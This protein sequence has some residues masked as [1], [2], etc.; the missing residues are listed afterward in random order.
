MKK[1]LAAMTA[2]LMMVALVSSTAFAAAPAGNSA[3]AK[4]CQKGGYL[5]LVGTAGPFATQD[6]C[7]NYAKTGILYPKTASL[8]SVVTGPF[9]GLGALVGNPQSRVAGGIADPAML[10]TLGG[11]SWVPGVAISLTYTAGAPLS[12]S[13][14]NPTA[15][16]PTA[17]AATAS[18]T[19]TLST[20]FQDNCFDSNNVLVSGPAIPY[21]ITGTNVDGQSASFAGTLNCDLIPATVTT[22][23]NTLAS[24]A[25][26]VLLTASGWHF[27]PNA[28]ITLSYDVTAPVLDGNYGS[29]A[30]FFT[31]PT[32]DAN[33]SFVWDSASTQLIGYYGDNC[34]YDTGSG[35]TLQTTNL[36]FTMTA[37]DG[38]HS[39]TATG[40]LKCSLLA[41]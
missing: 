32:A 15:Y 23:S 35:P 26:F 20:W 22:T 36:T 40:V 38:T 16:F 25:G 24:T 10:F 9:T 5:T 2:A 18:G 12:Y 21:T 7:V 6:A 11:A 13:Y 41:H 28:P 4:A 19:G 30:P 1:I 14:T 39:A 31:Q 27:T 8:T 3:G 34:V 17:P 33:G 29:L 37:S